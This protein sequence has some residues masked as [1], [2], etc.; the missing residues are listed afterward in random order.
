[1][2]PIDQ[3]RSDPSFPW[4]TLITTLANALFVRSRRLDWLSIVFH[5][6][7]LLVSAT[8]EFM[9]SFPWKTIVRPPN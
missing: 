2:R 4:K 8:I 9:I 5:G 1:M 3:L 6:K 7:L